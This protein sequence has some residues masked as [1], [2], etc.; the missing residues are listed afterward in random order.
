[1]AVVCAALATLDGGHSRLLLGDGRYAMTE[2][3]WNCIVTELMSA[4]D[5]GMAGEREERE[6]ERRVDLPVEGPL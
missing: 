3:S 6:R 5:G 1:M 4:R 2:G